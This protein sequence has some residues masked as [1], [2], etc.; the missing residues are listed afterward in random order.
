MKSMA[1]NDLQKPGVTKLPSISL[2]LS[3]RSK[4]VLINFSSSLLLRQWP[5]FATQ[6]RPL[7]QKTSGKTNLS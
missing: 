2:S 5:L 1:M 6:Q 4:Q 7:S 3:L